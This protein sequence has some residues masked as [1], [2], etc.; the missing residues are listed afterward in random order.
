[1]AGD[2]TLDLGATFNYK[3][4]ISKGDTVITS[5]SKKVTV[6]AAT[7]GTAA[8]ESAKI[9]LANDGT[10]DGENVEIK[11]GTLTVIAASSLLLQP[12]L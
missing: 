6:K 7:S 1:M 4:V 2:F 9:F 12:L 5:S 10:I 11:S 3:V 8:I